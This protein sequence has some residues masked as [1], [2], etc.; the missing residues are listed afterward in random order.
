MATHIGHYNAS[1]DF[2]HCLENL[3]YEVVYA[4][5]KGYE[6]GV[7]DRGFKF[8]KFNFV[9]SFSDYNRFSLKLIWKIV[10]LSFNNSINDVAFKKFKAEVFLLEELIKNG[11]Y[12]LIFVDS[13]LYLHSLVLHKFKGKIILLETMLSRI[14]QSNIPPLNSELRLRKNRILN[15]WYINWQWSK[16][17][18]KI[19]CTSF[20]KK[21]VYV[22]QNH[23]T[24]TKRLLKSEGFEICNLVDSDKNFF[25]NVKAVKEIVLS[26]IELDYPW[27][28]KFKNQFFF[29]GIRDMTS[30]KPGVGDNHKNI[31]EYIK[32]FKKDRNGKVLY[33]SLGSLAAIHYQ[34]HSRFLKI[35]FE[36]YKNKADRLLIIVDKNR[37]LK[38]S[39]L[40]QTK[41]VFILNNAPQKE[42]L[43]LCD[44]FITHGGLN[45]FIE[46]II[47][48][49]PMLLYP[50]NNHWDQIGN[51]SRAV[52][53][54]I[55]L[56]GNIRMDTAF[57]IEKK[58]EHILSDKDFL[59]SIKSLKRFFVDSENIADALY[60]F[61]NTPLQ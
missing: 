2:S 59:Y 28:I 26:P 36:A 46:S 22:N 54:K 20:L 51:A 41:E 35:V 47:S 33:C 50:L 49:T 8:I 9:D 3:G 10:T 21:I 25:F 31:I 56:M 18:F 40:D 4:G 29:S 19:A 24:L 13:F 61:I 27:R 60:E 15:K 45:S 17:F 14:R 7:Q 55:G 57:G 52:Y 5:D 16:H 44:L 39:E 58:C 11:D 34:N 1:Y 12:D 53:H 30:L 38:I 42:I 6:S 48:E 43:Q 23:I 32:N 37:A